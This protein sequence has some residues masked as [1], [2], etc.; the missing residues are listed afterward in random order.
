MS[1]DSLPPGR[2]LP[3]GW[4]W[5][6]L[7]ELI[8]GF[9]PGFA[10]G[11]RDPNGVVQVRMNNVTTGGSFN[12]EELI[13]VP[14]NYTNMDKYWIKA[15]DVLFNNTNSA[16]LVGKSAIFSDFE[17]QVVFSNHFSRL[18]PNLELL[19]AGFLAKWLNLN[20][21]QGLF[22]EICN[23]WVGQAAVPKQKLLQLNIPLPP[24]A[25]QK[26]IVSILNETVGCRRTSQESCRGTDR[27][28]AGIAGGDSE[29]D[30]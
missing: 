25:E 11:E 27:G 16:E 22:S 3:S 8:S 15:D 26:R 4:K 14:P 24:L 6:K 13:R 21:Q 28:G 10:C 1:F 12:W 23:R 29:R 7:G 5:V 18:R 20:W 2:N 17:E 19:D 9:Q 30:L